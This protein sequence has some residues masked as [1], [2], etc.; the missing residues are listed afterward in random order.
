MSTLLNEVIGKARHLFKAGLSVLDVSDN[1]PATG[2]AQI[3]SEKVFLFI[4]ALV[5]SNHSAAKV[6]KNTATHL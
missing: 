1:R 4:H 5:V 3:D 6:D 2:C